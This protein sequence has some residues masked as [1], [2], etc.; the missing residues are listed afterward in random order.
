MTA[1]RSS[2]RPILASW[3]CSALAGAA[4]EVEA[5]RDDRLAGLVVLPRRLDD[6][7]GHDGAAGL[8]L[9]DVDDLA[10]ARQHVA[11]LDR[12]VVGELLLAVQD[13]RALPVQRAH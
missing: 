4:D 8:L 1:T 7:N 2:R 3:S 6:H 13:Q 5:L 9:V 12:P 11:D 10:L